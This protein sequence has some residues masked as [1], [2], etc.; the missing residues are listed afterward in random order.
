ML[1]SPCALFSA[2]VARI[3][4]R[5]KHI[6]IKSNQN[7]WQKIVFLG[8]LLCSIRQQSSGYHFNMKSLHFLATYFVKIQQPQIWCLFR[9]HW[10][11]KLSFHFHMRTYLRVA[12]SKKCQ[13]HPELTGAAS[14]FQ[15]VWK[16]YLVPTILVDK[17]ISL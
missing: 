5:T 15:S 16:V 8:R 7:E 9:K 4:N 6:I 3:A 1:R 10:Y 2:L 11:W 17:M 13:H 12:S 14:W